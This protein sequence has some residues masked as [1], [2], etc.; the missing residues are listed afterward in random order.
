MILQH[1]VSPQTPTVTAA[2]DDVQQARS[3]D[4]LCG[5]TLLL[6]KHHDLYP[7]EDTIVILP[8][9]GRAESSTYHLNGLTGKFFEQFL[10]SDFK[11]VVDTRYE[12]NRI[13]IQLAKLVGY[14]LPLGP[15][16]ILGDVETGSGRAV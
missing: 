11:V 2:P 6:P 14:P 15:Q 9:S 4:R 13:D 7:Y 10:S 3:H 12:K 8:R 1:A 16:A 5:W